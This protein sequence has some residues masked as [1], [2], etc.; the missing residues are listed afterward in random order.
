MPR[1][2]VNVLKVS[3]TVAA[4]SLAWPVMAADPREKRGQGENVPGIYDTERILPY[5]G[6]ECAGVPACM[7]VESPLTVV[8]IDR[9]KVLAVSCPESHPFG[10]HW[11]TEQHE[12]IYVKLVGRT[13]TGLTFSV[14]NRA[15]AAGRSRIF[16]GCST[17]RFAGKGFQ[18]SRSGVPSKNLSLQGGAQ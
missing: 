10:W 3:V 11:D 15:N 9:V 17:E 2:N 5:V 7:T 4:L 16:V 6:N 18:L 12:H 8:D 13:R 1:V 14:S